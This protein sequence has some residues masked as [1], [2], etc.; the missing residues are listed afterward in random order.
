VKTKYPTT[1]SPAPSQLVTEEYHGIKVEDHYRNLENLQD[2][3]VQNWLKDQSDYANDVL[4]KI[5]RRQHLIDKQLEFDK[6]KSHSIA[7]LQITKDNHYFY[8]K[9]MGGENFAKLYYRKGFSGT[10]ELLY[11]PKEFKPES[12]FNYIINYIYPDWNGEKIVISLTKNGEEFSEM[13]IM[14]VATKN[15]LPDL[16]TNCFPQNDSYVSWLPDNSGFLYLHYPVI[17]FK[18]EACLKNTKSVYYKLGQNASLLNEVFSSTNNPELN[19]QPK[20]YPILSINSQDSKYVIGKLSG[21]SKFGDTYY[22]KMINPPDT[23]YDWKFLFSK[24]EKISS[25]IIN[26]EQLIFLSGKNA[27]NFQICKTSLNNPDF[28]NPM[29]LVNEKKEEVIQSMLMTVDGLFYV[30]NKNGVVAKLYHFK[31]GIE[32][33]IVLPEISG[34]VSLESKGGKYS[35]LW[36]STTGW[37]NSGR[38]YKYNSENKTFE[39]ADLVP[40]IPF[41]EFEELV[42]K[43]VLVKSHDGVEVPLS[44]IHKKGLEMNGKNPVIFL[45]Y[46]AYG[47]SLNSSFSPTR[48]LFTEEG[49]I[50]ATA[51]VR[52]GGEKGVEWHNG[53]KKTTKPNSW[54]D[55]IACT[56]YM[57]EKEYTSNK[58]TA[59]WSSSAGGILVG[60]AMTERPDLFAAVISV[61]G[62]MNKMRAENY[63]NGAANAKE[64]GTIENPEECKALF[65]MDAYLHLKKGVDYPATLLTAGM[66][67]LRVIV[68]QPAKFAAKLQAYQQSDKPILFFVDYE[69]G[70]GLGD[71]SMK[72]YESFA[73]VFAFTFWQTGHPEY[74]LEE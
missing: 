58:H 33:E 20:D 18:S 36:V 62:C 34:N 43:E 52:G 70:H 29:V 17:D 11:D 31:D 73:N 67:D 8:L 2:V 71:S 57:I 66:N 4:T 48:L 55:L 10:E 63:P 53:G 12:G 45:A 7:C 39:E 24:K 15:L 21:T 51:H 69:A 1:P 13:I 32:T 28:K 61:V 38:R 9:K 42:V 49:G 46:G 37:L 6:R 22:T 19:I 47:V 25:L 3:E 5:P 59:I 44:I 74:Q 50:L 27:T 41:P 26:E 23:K 30:T 35:D 64:F 40:I 54:K 14:E 68:W 60:R 16:I 65:E 72:R 56:E